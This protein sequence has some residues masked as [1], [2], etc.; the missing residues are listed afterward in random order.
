MGLYAYVASQIWVPRQSQQA[1]LLQQQQR[2][3]GEGEERSSEDSEW[4]LAASIPT[5]HCITSLAWPSAEAGMLL[6]GGTQ[7]G[8]VLVFEAP[9]P[10]LPAFEG[11]VEGA[12]GAPVTLAA[13]LAQLWRQPHGGWRVAAKLSPPSLV[14]VSIT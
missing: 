11:G 14:R 8:Q 2:Q 6:A 13:R 1:A 5:Q 10:A 7:D 3:S 4:V 12:A 9:R